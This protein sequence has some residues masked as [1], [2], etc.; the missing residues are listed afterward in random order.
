[1]EHIDSTNTRR[2]WMRAASFT[3]LRSLIILI[4]QYPEGL[5]ATELEAL[6]QHV[7]NLKTRRGQNLSR[8][9]L[10]H[11]RNILLHLGILVRKKRRYLVN[12]S[13][14][15]VADL[16]SVLSNESTVLSCHERIAFSRILIGN[17]D[18][19]YY[20]FDL[21]MP[22]HDSYKLN[23][24][25]SMGHRVAWRRCNTSSGCRVQL[26]NIDRQGVERWL[27]SQDELQAI[28]YGIRYWA[29]DEL[30]FIDELYLEDM[31]GVM[32]PVQLSGSA[33]DPNILA[34][35]IDDID[36]NEEWT[37][38]SV[39]RLAYSWGPR[40]KV[41]LERLFSTLLYVHGNFPEYVVLIPTSESFATLTARSP[42]ASKMQLRSYL[43]DPKGRYISHIRVHRKL[44]EVI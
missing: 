28:L 15:V 8:T 16:L 13:R 35:L 27:G 42:A 22:D 34:A 43:R 26:Y 11:Y 21:F 33:P 30:G 7:P 20:F 37:L 29:R 38:L 9:T 31:G 6:V 1:M 12:R 10:Y 41:P 2:P 36:R 40:Y 4:S 44:R 14:P 18:C 23:D 39:R 17:D 24:F 5:R 19:R 25:I 3:T 32:Y